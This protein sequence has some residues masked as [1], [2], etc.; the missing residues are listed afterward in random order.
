MISI[1]L[2]CIR[3]TQ[4]SVIRIIHHN[5]HLKRF[6]SILPKCLFVTIVIHENFIHISQCS[7]EM[8]LRCGGIYNIH[9]IA[10]CPQNVSVEEL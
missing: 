8:H 9:V 1:T 10:N 6:F 5:V 3:P 7:V 2:D 4:S